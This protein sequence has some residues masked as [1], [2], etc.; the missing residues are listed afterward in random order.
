MSEFE[1]S[2][3]TAV[4]KSMATHKRKAAD[5]Y[6]TPPAATQ[7]ILDEL[8][9]SVLRPGALIG[10][11]ACGEGDMA[12]VFRANGFDVIASDLRHTGYG[13]GGHD[14]L[15]G[16]LAPLEGSMG[17]VAE[18]GLLDAIITNPP[19]AV[20]DQFIRKAVQQAPVVAMLLKSNYWHA[21]KRADKL[22]AD[23][24]P[25]R[26]Y[27]IAWRLAFLEAERGKSPL[28]D[29]TWYVWVRGEK[30]IDRPLLRPQA[31]RVLDVRQK[32]LTVHLRRLAAACEALERA[33]DGW[34]EQT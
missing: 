8:C 2:I 6:P 18:Y 19:F 3:A 29:C 20:A 15:L 22:Y 31:A 13:I 7:A 25:T 30:P 5:E 14:Y 27:P 23:C 17:W 12:R 10:E 16:G 1:H 24:P 9:P 33:V 34:R 32:P 28:M 4:V 21:G 11:P 26:Q